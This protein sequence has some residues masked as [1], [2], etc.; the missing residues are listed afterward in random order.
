M[1]IIG[2]NAFEHRASPPPLEAGEIHLWYL[3]VRDADQSRNAAVKPA[4]HLLGQLLAFYAALDSPPV[5]CREP[6]GKPRMQKPVDIEFNV[7]HS[8]RWA[9][10]AFAR[11]Q[12]LGVDVECLDR[13]Q[14]FEDIAD[15]YFAPGEA[16]DLHLLPAS[17]RPAAFLALWT[18]KE[19]V[20]KALGTGLAFGLERLRFR[21]DDEG[22]P[23]A[24]VSIAADGGSVADWQ[25]LA[26]APAP[27]LLGALA[28]RGPPR[29]VRAMC[30]LA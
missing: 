27:A 20:V 23:D 25:L 28:W 5:I 11:G 21:L 17:L 30:W 14:R 3:T 19:A 29:H 8:S 2:A 7:S 12:P 1:Q 15:R 13:R 18:C 4:R 16:R 6:Y 10:L 9:L 26:L 24:L 22:R